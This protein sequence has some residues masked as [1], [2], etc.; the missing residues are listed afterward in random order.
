MIDGIAVV[1]D[2]S[3][4]LLDEQTNFH[5]TPIGSAIIGMIGNATISSIPEWL[6]P[7]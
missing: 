4:M 1:E 6:S 2:L 7:V 3:D 5:T